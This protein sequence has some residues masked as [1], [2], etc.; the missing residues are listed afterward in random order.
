MATYTLAS[1]PMGEALAA[2]I[3]SLYELN[4]AAIDRR[5][6]FN[7]ANKRDVVYSQPKIRAGFPTR[8]VINPER[9]RKR[10]VPFA[11]FLNRFKLVEKANGEFK[12]M[13]LH[14]TRGWKNYT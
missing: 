11:N 10:G 1:T 13:I 8:R 9:I 3:R 12:I 7:H 5:R 6:Y 2:K 14:A 4:R